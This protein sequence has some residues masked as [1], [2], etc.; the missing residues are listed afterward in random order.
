MKIYYKP[1]NRKSFS[2]KNSST[3]SGENVK[4][5]IEKINNNINSQEEEIKY[6]NK[7]IKGI[8]NKENLYNLNEK[9]F[10]K[11]LNIKEIFTK[12]NIEQIASNVNEEKRN[13]LLKLSLSEKEKEKNSGRITNSQKNEKKNIYND[14]EMKNEINNQEK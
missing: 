5:K 3:D 4:N 7:Y 8:R 1:S 2:Q 9:N 11:K 6:I 13:E 14:K 10:P 12:M